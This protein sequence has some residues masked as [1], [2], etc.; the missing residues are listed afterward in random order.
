[1]CRRGDHPSG[2]PALS[3]AIE[4]FVPCLARSTGLGPA[5]SPAHG[6]LGMQPSTLMSSS[7]NP[8]RRAIRRRAD[9]ER[10]IPIREHVVGCA[11]EV[12]DRQRQTR[13]CRGPGA[14]QREAHRGPAAVSED[15]H[16]REQLTRFAVDGPHAHVSPVG[17]GL[18]SGIRLEADL[19]LATTAGRS[20]RAC[21]WNDGWL[22]VYP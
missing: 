12:V 11:A 6:A 7:C 5:I 4:R 13:Q 2:I 15:G 18:L 9:H 3:M 22:P 16:K 8:M 1:M 21:R 14:V 19:G 10:G 17:L 20:R